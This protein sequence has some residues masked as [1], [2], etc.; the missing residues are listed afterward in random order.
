MNGS[1]MIEICGV[2]LARSCRLDVPRGVSGRNI[3][4]PLI[5]SLCECEPAILLKEGMVKTYKRSHDQMMARQ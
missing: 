1:G 3:D 5:K 2:R 4:N